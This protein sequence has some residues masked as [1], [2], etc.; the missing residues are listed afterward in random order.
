MTNSPYSSD[1]E[2]MVDSLVQRSVRAHSYNSDSEES[3][4]GIKRE[5]YA[6]LK[7]Q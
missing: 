6:G 1:N 7:E 4:D 2:E 3:E 5:E